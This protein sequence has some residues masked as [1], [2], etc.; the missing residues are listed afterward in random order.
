[1]LLSSPQPNISS[2]DLRTNNMP[3][4]DGKGMLLDDNGMLLE[5]SR[6]VYFVT[7]KF[8]DLNKGFS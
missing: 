4:F 1:M 2:Q 3:L 7:H 5:V 6:T 8:P